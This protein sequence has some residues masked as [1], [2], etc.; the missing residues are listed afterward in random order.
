M[1]RLVMPGYDHTLLGQTCKAIVDWQI[2]YGKRM[3]VPWGIS[4]SA[5]NTTDADLNYQ[6]RSF[7][8]P[9]MGFKRDLANDLVVAPYAT[10]L[11]LMVKPQDACKNMERLTADGYEGR[12]GFYEAVDFT[13]NR[14]SSDH[15][16]VL[17]RSFMAH[18]QGMSF[19]S[20]VNFIAGNP[21]ANRFEKD[22]LFRTTTLLLQ[23]RV[24]KASP[25]HIQP[26]GLNASREVK[27]AQ[28]DLLR[29]FPTAQTPIPEV[30]LLSNGRYHVMVTNA[31]GGYSRWGD[32]AV[33]RWNEDATMDNY[34]TFVYVKDLTTKLQWSAAFQPTC[35][36]P[37]SF[38]AIFSL[39]RAEFRRRDAGLDTY[40]EIAV[41]R[42]SVV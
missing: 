31:G 16:P 27:Q 7:G 12:Y 17:I 10:V 19:V 2:D 41:D 32:I 37:K 1:P 24:P 20:I 28:E 42:K 3:G 21:M 13:P 5:E 15:L 30:H 18:H 14:L 9:G 35:D 38:E 4:E 26:S 22:P 25:F 29:I 8:V 34:G 23:E 33:T 40:T 39:G 6:Y 36:E 11:A